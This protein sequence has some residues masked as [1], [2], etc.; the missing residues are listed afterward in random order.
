VGWIEKNTFHHSEFSNLDELIDLKQSKKL[1]IS[2][3]FPTLN[4]EATVGESIEIIKEILFDDHP[5]LDEI[6]VID[7]GSTDRT[8]EVGAEAGAKVFSSSEILPQLEWHR[9][10]GENLWKSLYVLEG[11]IIVWLDADIKNI[12]PKFVYGLVGPLL[13]HDQLQFVKAYYQRPIHLGG[14]EHEYGGGRVTEILVRPLFSLFFP[15]LAQLYQPCSGECAGRRKLLESLPFAAGYGIETGMLID[16]YKRYG[17]EVMAQTNLDL[18][19]HRNQPASALGKMGFEI[20][21]AFLK[22]LRDLGLV[23]LEKELSESYRKLDMGPDLYSLKEEMV[24]I[25]ER[26]PILEIPEYLARGSQSPSKH[27]QDRV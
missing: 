4:E 11:D 17:P 14:E 10:K 1:K 21:H 24:Q 19:I 2:L 8:L 5:L 25:H 3:A 15:E 13:K 26:P 27:L 20:L 6:V 22:R 9:G 7:S 12:H 16:I 23:E 18:R